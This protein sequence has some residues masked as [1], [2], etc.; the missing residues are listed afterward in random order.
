LHCGTV[1]YVI[2]VKRTGHQVN[3]VSGRD[4]W[5]HDLMSLPIANSKCETEVMD[6]EDPLYILYTS[7]TNGQA[8]GDR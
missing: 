6:A 8:E 1:E 5:Y 7:G 4:M 2:V 3:M